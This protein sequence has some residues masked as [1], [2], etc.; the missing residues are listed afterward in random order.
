MLLS[1]LPVPALTVE[2]DVAMIGETGY[3]TLGAAIT[4]ARAGEDKVIT[5]IG[6]VPGHVFTNAN[7][8]GITIQ[9]SE[10][11][12]ITGSFT[13]TGSTNSFA[14]TV[15]KNLKFENASIILS[16]A[17]TN[18]AGLTIRDCTFMGH[19]AGVYGSI[20]FQMP[21]SAPYDGLTIT[22]N[23]IIHDGTEDDASGI[24]ISGGGNTNSG[25]ITISD[26][27]VSDADN[28]ALQLH[29]FPNASN[30]IISGN[31]FNSNRGSCVSLYNT[32]A[33]GAFVITDNL[34]SFDNGRLL[35]YV[36]DNI[37]ATGNTWLNLMLYWK[38][39]Q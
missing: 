23:T 29:Q 25:S 26:N 30:V 8:G 7:M 18:F 13:A 24:R 17:V 20:H 22:G 39:I 19:T 28:N 11:G 6:E 3:P 9:G 5:V 15:F 36:S 37:T 12:K 31:T 34:I 2:G 35:G 10:T 4:A 21:A 33:S 14:G 38:L 1:L 27:A 32:I 16:T